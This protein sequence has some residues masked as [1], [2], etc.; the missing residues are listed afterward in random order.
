MFET[1]PILAASLDT[2]SELGPI[3]SVAHQFGVTWPL[4]IAQIVNFCLVAFLLYKFAFKPILSTMDLR[5]RKISDGLQYAQ[6]MKLRLEE[7]EKHYADAIR[8]AS[9]EAQKIIQEAREA[10]KVHL[11]QSHQEAAHKTEYMLDQAQES[12][13]IERDKMLAALRKEVTDL[14][15]VTTERVLAKELSEQERSRFSEAAANELST[16]AKHV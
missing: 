7:S 14:V 6:E 5:Q 11:E 9:V 15:V 8:K 12:I 1:F 10:G 16:Q 13:R 4:L 3:E 2:A